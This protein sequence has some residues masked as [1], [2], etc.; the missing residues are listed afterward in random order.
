MAE[1]NKN[2]YDK[3]YKWILVIPVLFLIFS[4]VYLHNFDSK[5]GDVIYKDTSLTGGTT[6]TLFDQKVEVN[7]LKA[8]LIKE[9]PDLAVRAISNIRTGGQEGVIIE[10]KESSAVVVAAIEKEVGYKLT[11]DNSSVE[12]T[13]AALSTGFYQQ[14]ISA[15]IAAFLLM[16]WVVFLIFSHDKEIKGIATMLV[17]LGVSLVLPTVSALRML[18]GFMILVGLVYGLIW[19]PKNRRTYLTVCATALISY[20]IFF[21]YSKFWVAAVVGAVLIAL[22]IYYSIPSFAVILCAFADIAM[23]V[24]VVDLIG[25][26]L[27]IAGV[28][29]FLMLIGYSVDTDILLTSRLLKDKEGNVNHRIFGAFKTGMTMTLTAIAS[30]GVSLI[31]IYQFSDTLRQIFTIILIG[32]FFDIINTWITNASILKWYMEVKK[33]E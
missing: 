23:T 31:I 12:F 20:L 1:L 11:R 2:W 3:S 33:I 17:F 13:G 19:G 10:S 5:N 28:I 22:F 4:I 21:F 27:S 15:I 32:L 25:L 8:S 18:S 16:S 9:F 14:L 29:A 30:V 6:V 7:T 26:N 24:A